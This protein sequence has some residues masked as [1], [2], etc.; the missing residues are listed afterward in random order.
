MV[1]I[2]DKSAK[3]ALD[4]ARLTLQ[5]S[6]AKDPK[7]VAWDILRRTKYSDE[8]E[9]EMLS[10]KKELTVNQFKGILEQCR[11]ADNVDMSEGLEEKYLRFMMISGSQEASNTS[12]LD[13]IQSENVNNLLQL[14][15][16]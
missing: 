12:N 3:L 13:C 16:N 4:H 8:V 5:Y 6:K 7:I 1:P 11:I 10:L 2:N 15:S 14:C 9:L